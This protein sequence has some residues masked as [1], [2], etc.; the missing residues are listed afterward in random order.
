[1][2]KDPMIAKNLI[3]EDIPPL[4][5]E[6]SAERALHWMDEFHVSHLAV[7]KG[8]EFMGM[9]SEND[10]YDLDE[11]DAPIGSH[12]LTLIKPIVHADQH[13]YDVLRL[14]AELNLD[15]IAV[16]D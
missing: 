1:M 9:I 3:N 4:K 14:M 6:D 8:T 16:T 10:L 2:P 11:P 5:I 15:V 7:V 13:V 12:R